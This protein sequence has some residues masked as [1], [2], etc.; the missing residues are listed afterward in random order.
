MQN[1]YVDSYSKKSHYLKYIVY[2]LFL[3]KSNNILSNFILKNSTISHS[4][5]KSFFHKIQ[6]ISL[7]FFYIKK[8][9]IV[10]I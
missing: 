1:I 5:A 2:N 10:S 8:Y 3:Q 6:N 4:N 7:D 9:S